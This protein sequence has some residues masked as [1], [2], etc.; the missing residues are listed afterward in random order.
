MITLQEN[1]K[2]HTDKDLTVAK[3]PLIAAQSADSDSGVKEILLKAENGYITSEELSQVFIKGKITSLDKVVCGNGMS[4]A[5]FRTIP[6]PY[7]INILISPSKKFVVSKMESYNNG[8]MKT[9]NKIAFYYGGSEDNFSQRNAVNY[10]VLVFVADSFDILKDEIKQL[11]SLVDKVL[12][13]EGHRIDLDTDFRSRLILFKEKVLEYLPESAIVVGTATPLLYDNIDVRFENRNVPPLIIDVERDVRY[14]INKSKGD[15]KR[16]IDVIVGS[17]QR[18]IIE[19][20]KSDKKLLKA[21]F[22]IG[23]GMANKLTVNNSIEDTPEASLTVISSTAF[24]GFDYINKEDAYGNFKKVNAYLFEDRNEGYSRFN[25][26]SVFQFFNRNRIGNNKNIYCRIETTK[27]PRIKDLEKTEKKVDDF[28]AKEYRNIK[29]VKTFITKSSKA[30]TISKDST[31]KKYINV[32]RDHNYQDVLVFRKNEVR[33]KIDKEHYVNDL[34]GLQHLFEGDSKMR[35]FLDERNIKINFPETEILADMI[36][37]KSINGLSLETIKENLYKNKDFIEKNNL[38]SEFKLAFDTRNYRDVNLKNAMKQVLIYEAFKDYKRDYEFSIRF[39]RGK[40]ILNDSRKFDVLQKDVLK[41]YRDKQQY[42][43]DIGLQTREETRDNIKIF[44]RSYKKKI[45]KLI[46]LLMDERIE[47]PENYILNRDYNLLVQFSKD[48]LK[49]ITRALGIQF[50]E[51]DIKSCNIRIVYSLAGKELPDN[52]YGKD[53]KNKSAINMLMNQMHYRKNEF[54]KKVRI[55]QF[56]DLG[57]DSDIA[58]DFVNQY[59]GSY[60]ERVFEDMTYHEMVIIDDLKKIIKT[61]REEF[62]GMV[63]RHDSLIMFDYTPE[64][65]DYLDE[66]TYNNIGGDWF[67]I[68][69][70]YINMTG[71]IVAK[72]WS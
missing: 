2:S 31:L 65:Y 32:I 42:K 60:A 66:F 58:I 4:T 43:Q 10:D 40:E 3:I 36:D 27:T 34:F 29:S 47:I 50:T 57:I 26:G 12:L 49:A 22:Y 69:G 53:K 7:K 46:M 13:D 1:I 63:R 68:D 25:I 24:D 61:S 52:I 41:K 20:L 54:S 5:F 48:G 71:K 44:K 64:N 15:L 70:E 23:S 67:G 8:G 62:A 19:E 45:I 16:G 39:K 72:I 11:G 37:R 6:E 55:K 35:M 56:I 51:I 18:E 59:Y 14:T 9:S 28:L 33:F 30:K 38:A 21:H 17:N